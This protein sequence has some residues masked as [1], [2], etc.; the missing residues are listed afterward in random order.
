MAANLKRYL[1]QY[2][3]CQIFLHVVS[4]KYQYLC[5]CIWPHACLRY[6]FVYYVPPLWRYITCII[7]WGLSQPSSNMSKVTPNPHSPTPPCWLQ[8]SFPLLLY[9][10][11]CF[12]SPGRGRSDLQCIIK[13]IDPSKTRQIH[14]A[15]LTQHAQSSRNT[16]P[17]VHQ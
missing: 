3:N 17:L 10:Y 13:A 2:L 8:K 5:I 14:N 16:V 1:K 7:W 4:I 15:Q 9:Y 12:S 11:V 6:A